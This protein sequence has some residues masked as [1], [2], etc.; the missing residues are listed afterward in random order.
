MAK[1]LKITQSNPK[2]IR[3]IQVLLGG[4]LMMISL[5]LIIAFSSYIINWKVDFS[6]L[7]S[8]TDKTVVAKNLLNKVG[9]IL[10]H[11]FIYQGV[12]LGAIFFPYLFALTGYK[13]FFDRKKNRLIS[14]WAWGITHLLWFSIALGYIFPNEILLSGIVG[15]EINIFFE[16][17][18]GSIGIF[19]L[20]AFTFLCFIVIE[21]GWTPEKMKHWLSQI[22]NKNSQNKNTDEEILTE[23]VPLD[24]NSENENI[25]DEI[26]TLIS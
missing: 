25:N 2:L 13:F 22:S 5:I 18:I 16:S 3:Q 6:T 10:S 23:S 20:L 17:Y 8:F 26:S 7:G 1:K 11:Y 12:G 19:A 9:A 15:Y 21:L 14:S 4:G 24:L